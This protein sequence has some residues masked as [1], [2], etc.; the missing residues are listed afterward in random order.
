MDRGFPTKRASLRLLVVAVAVL[1]VGT[2]ALAVILSRAAAVLSSTS[3][4]IANRSATSIVALQTIR[5]DV[6]RQ[7][8]LADEWVLGGPGDSAVLAASM[9]ALRRQA[10]ESW[11]VYLAVP[12]E[13]GEAP[14]RKALLASLDRFHSVVDQV[15][16]LPPGAGANGSAALY[17]LDSAVG[18]V[19]TDLAHATDFWAEVAKAASGDAMKVSRTLLPSAL[20]LG[21]MSAAAAVLTIALTYRSVRR[22]EAL[23]DLSRRALEHKA[24]ELEAF[25]GRVAHD[26]LSPLMTVGLGLDLAR[27]RAGALED[28][29]AGAAI[30]RAVTTLKRV[31]G[32]VSDLLEFARAGAKPSP[33][34]RARVDEIIHEVAS[35]FEPIAQDAHVELRVERV[36]SRGVRCSPGVLASLVSNLVQNAIKY[37]VSGD[38]R[39]I[40]VR[41]LDLGNE[42]R[43]EVQDMGPGIPA[44]DQE[45]LFDPLVRGQGASGP[46]IGLGLAIVRRLAE[47]HGGLAGM[48]SDLGQGALFWFSVPSDD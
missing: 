32:F 28:D 7:H 38:A 6:Q 27:R 21:I 37:G 19:G 5:A 2:I 43:I 44:A 12:G 24:E 40:D 26:L 47:A 41:A 11:E 3:E 31:R 46:G 30:T 13:P 22:A 9:D 39:R 15:R 14:P 33:G 48:R 4:I 29:R 8:A 25:A 23:A 17:D 1:F 36:P 35:E 42:V 45:R 18:Q 10:T 16:A 34:V 20:I